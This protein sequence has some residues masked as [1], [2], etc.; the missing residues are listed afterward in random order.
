MGYLNVAEANPGSK[1]KNPNP[2]W[3][4]G[5]EQNKHEICLPDIIQ[6]HIELLCEEI[7]NA[8]TIDQKIFR[9]LKMKMKLAEFNLQWQV[10]SAP[11]GFEDIRITVKIMYRGIENTACD[12]IVMNRAEEQQTVDDL[13]SDDLLAEVAKQKIEDAPIQSLFF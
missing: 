2:D 1:Y 3:Q 9:I 10:L 13:T 5:H 6:Q 4:H 7:E 8:T 12:F 11:T